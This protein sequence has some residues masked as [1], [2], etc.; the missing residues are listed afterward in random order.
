MYC[1]KVSDRCNWA[2]KGSSSAA[3]RSERRPGAGAAT[4]SVRV[5]TK[6]STNSAGLCCESLLATDERTVK[7][8]GL[9]RCLRLSPEEP[10]SARSINNASSK[11]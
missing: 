2:A 10:S 3:L 9:G 5:W 11:N 4:V 6:L 1:A 8:G 7:C